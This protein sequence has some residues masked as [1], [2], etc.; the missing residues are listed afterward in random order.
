LRVIFPLQV[1]ISF[2]NALVMAV[3]A[4]KTR[5]RDTALFVIGCFLVIL[6]SKQV[7]DEDFDFGHEG[8]EF[9]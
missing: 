2:I 7:F 8:L 3:G 4:N 1:A 9:V 5:M 6:F